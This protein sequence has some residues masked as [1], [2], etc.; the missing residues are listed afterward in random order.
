M[1]SPESVQVRAMLQT[2]K[3]APPAANIEEMRAGLE[4]LSGQTPLPADTQVEKVDVAG[5]PSEWVSAPHVASDRA[6][7]YLHGGAYLLGS[8]NTHR[9]LAARLSAA[10]GLRVLVVDYRLAPEHLFPAAVED[11][12][13][14]YRW[15]LKSGFSPKHL[16]IAGDS[17]GGGLSAATLVALRDAGDPL[18]AGAV[19]LSPWTDLA[20]TGE[21]LKTRAELD[22]WLSPEGL[23]PAAQMYLGQ[24]DARHPLA[25]PIYADLHGL[26][27]LLIQVGTDEIIHDDSTRL[28]ERAIAADVPVKLDIWEGMW[29]VWQSF[30]Y[31]LPEGRQAIEQIGEFVRPLVGLASTTGLAN[32]V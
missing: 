12:T 16:V 32:N 7:L 1:P 22:P 19:L 13:A 17:A 21:S 6:M 5:I 18:P 24:T 10:C 25:S 3:H 27:P 15:L 30:A 23:A 31:S 28:A 26:P 2:V 20:A 8:L 11:G 4:A 14:A 29:H 9:E